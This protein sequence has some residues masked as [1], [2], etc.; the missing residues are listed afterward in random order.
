MMSWEYPEG[1]G[2]LPGESPEEVAREYFIENWMTS[3]EADEYLESEGIDP[4][5][6]ADEIYDILL[7]R[8]DELFDERW[9]SGDDYVF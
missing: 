4:H 7:E 3:D 8:A 1:T 6:D 2:Y 9:E 5:S